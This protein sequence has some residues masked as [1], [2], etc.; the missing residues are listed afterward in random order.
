MSTVEELTQAFLKGTMSVELDS[1]EFTCSSAPQVLRGSGHLE[2]TGPMRS[3]LR[4]WITEPTGMAT[5]WQ[6]LRSVDS[7]T[8]AGTL[9]TDERL[10][11]ATATDK[12]GRVFRFP[13]LSPRCMHFPGRERVASEVSADINTCEIDDPHDPRSDRA[14]RLFIEGATNLPLIGWDRVVTTRDGSLRSIG[15]GARWQDVTTT[16]G[17]LTLE[18]TESGVMVQFAASNL[19]VASRVASCVVQALVFVF[20]KPVNWSALL[21]RALEGDAVFLRCMGTP[22]NVKLLEPIGS[23]S[24]LPEAHH[25][26]NAF[27]TYFNFVWKHGP[28]T[29]RWH[30]MSEI[31]YET[32][33]AAGSSVYLMALAFGVAM[34]TALTLLQPDKR[35]SPSP[36]AS[37]DIDAL[38]QHIGDWDGNPEL[39]ARVQGLV[40]MAQSESA[41]QRFQRWVDAGILTEQHRRSWN[42]IRHPAAHGRIPADWGQE[43]FDNAYIV[44][45]GLYRIILQTI[46]Y[47]GIRRNTAVRDWPSEEFCSTAELDEEDKGSLL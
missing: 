37:A 18:G 41:R 30:P 16:G 25:H 32:V 31:W 3:R 20:G 23:P 19:R 6:T 13:G 2:S 14:F 24:I 46:G 21:L 26:W 28:H 36:F 39:A 10:F 47:Y 1:I 34:E 38:R 42:A 44:L 22:R 4:V 17:V 8:G 45:D 15:G 27:R 29:D 12:R 40:A 11:C 35:P 43:F 7:P 5:I 33:Q 9:L